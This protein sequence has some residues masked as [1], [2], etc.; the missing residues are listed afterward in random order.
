M[1]YAAGLHDRPV[2]SI[3]R[4][5]V[6][7]LISTVATARGTTT[8]MRCRAALSRF[9]SWLIAKDKVE[10]NPVTGTE[11]YATPA[12]DRV[13]TDGELAAIWAATG[14][15]TDFGLIIRL[16]L[17]TGARRSEVGSM[18]WWELADG[19]WT[20]A[21]EQDEESPA[22]GA[23]AAPAGAGG[24]P[25][26]SARRRAGPGVRAR[27]GRVS[28]VVEGQGAARSQAGIRPAV[29]PAR[30]A[31]HRPNPADRAGRRP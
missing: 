22:T 18:G 1:V 19:V 21:G 30:L 9:F 25:G 13:L 23:A 3:R 14:D 10:F 17:W 2:G 12:R 4:G 16:L 28:G 20:V 29:G 27:P 31:A 15:G 26:A 5:D 24:A 6:A 11:G 8:A 7:D